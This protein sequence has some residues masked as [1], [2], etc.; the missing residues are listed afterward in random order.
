M[1][2][3]HSTWDCMNASKIAQKAWYRPRTRAEDEAQAQAQAKSGAN[4]PELFNKLSTCSG[5]L[6]AHHGPS[7][8][9][10]QDCFTLRGYPLV[11]I[12]HIIIWSITQM[13]H[14]DMTVFRQPPNFVAMHNIQYDRY[15][16]P[17]IPIQEFTLV[18]P[19][20]KNSLGVIYGGQGV[21]C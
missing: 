4:P 7:H 5:C 20:T 6:S 3:H 9:I 15:T 16:F 17:L 11:P 18:S 21:A 1:H 2:R 13:S 10:F 19:Q 8:A 14:R 12:K